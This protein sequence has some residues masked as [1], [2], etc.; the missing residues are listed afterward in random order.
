M[1]NVDMHRARYAALSVG[2]D[3]RAAAFDMVGG[4]DFERV[5]VTEKLLL[6]NYA[7]VP[8]GGMLIDVGCGPGRLARY[9]ADRKTMSY[10]GTDVVPELLVV[11]RKECNRP[12]WNFV[13]VDGFAIPAGRNTADVVAIFSVFTNI[14]P[15]QSL[16]LFREAWRVL[17][18]GGS[19]LITYFDITVASHQRIFCDLV[20]HHEQR[21]DPLVFLDRNFIDFFAANA[22]FTD[23]RH[24]SPEHASVVT[25]GEVRLKDGR[26]HTGPFGLNQAMTVVRKPE[27]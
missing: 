23:V 12:D 17:K 21:I 24:I 25:D 14:W 2:K 18:P 16:L 5:G 20:Q 6:D 9:L 3:E 22:G 10:L 8:E 15:E 7:P 11:A 13:E 19:L 4:G 27:G 26:V 1:H